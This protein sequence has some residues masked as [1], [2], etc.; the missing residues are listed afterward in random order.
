VA[1]TRKLGGSHVAGMR[2]LGGSQ[3]G[4]RVT[5][6]SSL[7]CTSGRQLTSWGC[8]ASRASTRAA[9]SRLQAAGPRRGGHTA[10]VGRAMMKV[11]SHQGSLAS[12]EAKEGS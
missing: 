12:K 7:A 3:A 8:A 11:C 10:L 2:K 1:W 4:C 9:L 5:W 6:E